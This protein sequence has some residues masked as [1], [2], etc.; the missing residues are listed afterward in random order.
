M[1]L[2]LL[3]VRVCRQTIMLYIKMNTK[4]NTG[5]LSDASEGEGSYPIMVYRGNTSND[6]GN[7]IA[8]L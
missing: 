5:M 2:L 8:I 1:D 6:S 7:V 4:M 3:Y